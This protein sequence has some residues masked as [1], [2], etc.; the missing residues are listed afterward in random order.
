[1]SE[2]QKTQW[3]YFILCLTPLGNTWLWYNTKQET[4]Y[5]YTQ[6]Q[7]SIWKMLDI[8]RWWTKV[9]IA[10]HELSTGPT[11]L[12]SGFGSRKSWHFIICNAFH[13]SFLTGLFSFIQSDFV[14]IWNMNKVCFKGLN[15]HQQHFW[16]PRIIYKVELSTSFVLVITM[17][18]NHYA[19][20][21]WKI[22]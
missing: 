15:E 17:V 13:W 20:P 19:K 9:C 7:L 11:V 18:L 6:R 22:T 14:W 10:G 8:T 21:R 16:F 5:F 4:I 1:M 3:T 12:T 2:K